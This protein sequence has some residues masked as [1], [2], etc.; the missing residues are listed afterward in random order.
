MTIM[1]IEF[2]TCGKTEEAVRLDLAACTSL[3]DVET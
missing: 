1:T 2:D 3:A